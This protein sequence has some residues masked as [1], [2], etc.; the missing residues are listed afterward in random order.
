MD[1]QTL[2]AAINRHLRESFAESGEVRPLGEIVERVSEELVSSN[3]QPNALDGSPMVVPIELVAAL[4]DGNLSPEESSAVCQAAMGD[5]RV[6]SEVIGA[7]RAVGKPSDQLPPLSDSLSGQ[8]LAMSKTLPP[9]M[10]SPDVFSGEE[11]ARDDPSLSF[12]EPTAQSSRSAD[13]A[14]V[15]SLDAPITGSRLPEIKTP[16]PETSSETKKTTTWSKVA[17]KDSRPWSLVWGA[18][19]IA[20][21][22]VLA[23]VWW[24]R[25]AANEISPQELTQKDH[26]N[27]SFVDP[28]NDL[29]LR[30]DG[31]L[32]SAPPGSDSTELVEDRPSP[33]PIRPE[34]SN[35]IEKFP[36]IG[37]EK[38]GMNES[39]SSDSIAK[40]ASATPGQPMDSG[41]E[42]TR[43]V[44]DWE[45]PQNAEI[46]AVAMSNLQWTDVS[47]ILTQQRM[48]DP[49]TGSSAGGVGWR[50]V[51]KGTVTPMQLFEGTDTA[52]PTLT[53]DT[54]GPPVLRTLPF[55]RAVAKLDSGGKLVM[56]SDTAMRVARWAVTASADVELQ[57]GEM[58]LVD[59]PPGTVVRLRRANRILAR[60]VWETEGTAVVQ[61]S[62]VGLHVHVGKGTVAVNDQPKTD[63]AV[64]VKKD[65]SVAQAPQ[66]KRIPRW[67]DQN[68]HTIPVK[69]VV[70]AQIADSENVISSIATQFNQMARSRK[71]DAASLEMLARWQ[72]AAAGNQL[73]RLSGQNNAMIRTMA[74]ERILTL[75][76]MDSR[77]AGIWRSVGAVVSDQRRLTRLKRLSLMAQ[78]GESPLA[79]QITA[80][81]D[82]LRS[83]NVPSRAMAD[84]LLRYFYR[85][86]P[87]PLPPFDPTATGQAQSR[88]I[89]A[90]KV[91]IR[92]LTQSP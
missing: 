81:A 87:K 1:S 63:E 40:D 49:T 17:K 85:N 57:H 31:G 13:S 27:G 34:A 4:V 51:S 58:A 5:R 24:N 61:E 47:G 90:W 83:P 20:A 14:S 73:L 33:Q 37:V 76:Q 66:P 18:L 30:N 88:M 75:S 78:R 84:Y 53:R 52:T 39:A 65:A 16:Q 67:V 36:G 54:V 45:T 64:V 50:G 91:Y 43:P 25:P 55:C 92:R 10:L 15:G 19:A 28:N 77:Y 23:V 21:S 29:P 86:G 6:L 79:A 8:L 2:L 82:D 69:P 7:V 12:S 3:G 80:L 89:N 41:P 68:I 38:D 22:I 35:D 44:P 11:V 74:I 46:T 9:D 56:G 59:L 60:L 71:P 32:D 72:V 42:S 62:T 48:P 26:S 70:L